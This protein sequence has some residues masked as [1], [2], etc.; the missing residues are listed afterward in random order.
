MK[1]LAERNRWTAV[2]TFAG[3]GFFHL[4]G[5]GVV[6]LLMSAGGGAGDRHIS[7]GR[8]STLQT[9]A[10]P[11][12]SA[13]FPAPASAEFVGDRIEAVWTA[14]HKDASGPWSIDADGRITWR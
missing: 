3:I 14:R 8:P 5:F 11:A 1:T 12:P 4:V 9:V 6:A 13:G 7:Q 2:L 10:P